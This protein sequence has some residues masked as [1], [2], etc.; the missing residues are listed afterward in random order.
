VRPLAFGRRRAAL[1]R[2]RR[3]PCL[4]A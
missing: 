2:A 3:L 1:A 4:P